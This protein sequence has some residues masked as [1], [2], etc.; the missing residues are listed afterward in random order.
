MGSLGRKTEGTPLCIVHSRISGLNVDNL[1][2]CNLRL[3]RQN[4]TFRDV[5]VPL[6]EYCCSLCDHKLCDSD[7]SLILCSRYGLGDCLVKIFGSARDHEGQ[8]DVRGFH[9]WHVGW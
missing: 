5:N 7:T 6:K 4:N 2:H 9:G 3:C 1:Q 8:N